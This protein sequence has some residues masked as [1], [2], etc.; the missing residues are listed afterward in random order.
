MQSYATRCV[1][2]NLH[3][4]GEEVYWSKELGKS[5][6][7]FPE[8]SLHL[9]MVFKLQNVLMLKPSTQTVRVSN[10]GF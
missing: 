1:M 9:G 10:V 5:A 3:C 4:T 7:G 8:A 6:S 2:C